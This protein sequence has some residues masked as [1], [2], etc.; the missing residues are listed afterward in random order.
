MYGQVVAL[1]QYE[2]V[3]SQWNGIYWKNRY[4]EEK[5]KVFCCTNMQ[6]SKTF[7]KIGHMQLQ[8]IFCTKLPD[9]N[10]IAYNKLQS[11]LAK[12]KNAN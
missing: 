8:A 12:E 10:K 3:R 2:L 9:V 5:Q 6:L 7:G 4:K 1:E 11:F